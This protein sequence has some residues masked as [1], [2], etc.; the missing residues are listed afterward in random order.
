MVPWYSI[1]RIIPIQTGSL[2]HVILVVIV[3]VVVAVATA[4]GATSLK[5]LSYQ[6]P[7]HAKDNTPGR[8]FQ[9]RARVQG[10]CAGT[11]CVPIL[12]FV[13]HLGHPSC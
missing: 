4:A 1:I 8:M 3:V 5:Q 2:R 7:L 12:R 10:K 13:V 6:L 11:A 9:I